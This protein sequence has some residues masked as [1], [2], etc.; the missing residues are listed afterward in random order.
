[1]QNTTIDFIVF[2]TFFIVIFFTDTLWYGGFIHH[3]SI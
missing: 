2:I 1:M 3:W